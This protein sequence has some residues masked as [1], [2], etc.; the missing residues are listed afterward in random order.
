MRPWPRIRIL[1]PFR[2]NPR[3]FI[4]TRW[5]GLPLSTKI[6]VPAMEVLSQPP[7]RSNFEPFLPVIMLCAPTAVAYKTADVLQKLHCFLT[8]IYTQQ[9]QHLHDRSSVSKLVHVLLL[10][11]VLLT[12][13][14]LS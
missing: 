5:S 8:Q 3:L 9:T 10:G 13:Q 1:R 4:R 6:K 2:K 7:T 14:P 11:A 12:N